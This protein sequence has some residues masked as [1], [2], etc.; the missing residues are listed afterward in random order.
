MTDAALLRLMRVFPVGPPAR[1]VV[2]GRGLAVERDPRSSCVECTYRTGARPRRL[3]NATPCRQAQRI[4]ARRHQSLEDVAPN[5]PNRR[6]PGSA[7]WLYAD[8]CI[9][10]KARAPPCPACRVRARHAGREP[11]VPSGGRPP[12]LLGR[13]ATRAAAP[14]QA[15]AGATPPRHAAAP[16][17]AEAPGR[18]RRHS[19]APRGGS[20]PRRGSRPRPAPLPAPLP[21]PFP[22]A[23]A[24]ARYSR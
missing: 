20:T 15:A 18:G 16:R 13:R 21:A 1:A 9:S 17:H 4:G 24:P 6:M 12:G 8:V 10:C 7:A 14:R 11:A 2:R 22:R 23:T 19:P 3:D 5:A